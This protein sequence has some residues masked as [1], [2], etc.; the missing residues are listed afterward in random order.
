MKE[1]KS[2][3][4]IF[5]GIKAPLEGLDR[6]RLPGFQSYFKARRG[7]FRDLFRMEYSSDNIKKAFMEVTD[8]PPTTFGST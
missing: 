3:N 7:H 8:K 5:G 4:A 6:S 2:P 1:Q